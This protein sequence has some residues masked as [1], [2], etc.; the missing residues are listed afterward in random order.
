MSDQIDIDEEINSNSSNIS[1]NS[2]ENVVHKPWNILAEH[3]GMKIDEKFVLKLTKGTE[4]VSKEVKMSCKVLHFS[5]E[6]NFEEL[7]ILLDGLIH[8]EYPNMFVVV[9]EGK[10]FEFLAENLEKCDKIKELILKLSQARPLLLQ[11]TSEDENAAK[12]YYKEETLDY[13]I[14]IDETTESFDE[15]KDFPTLLCSFLA[16]KID[17]VDQI[18]AAWRPIIKSSLSLKFLKLFENLFYKLILEVAKSGEKTDLLTILEAPV[19]YEGRVL[20]VE[21]HTYQK[22]FMRNYLTISQWNTS[23]IQ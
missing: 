2:N 22:Y 6:W 21:A 3:P 11:M 20:S 17:N 12:F 18:T 14:N 23:K 4:N 1:R 5:S 15:I 13:F 19:E 7:L 9:I 10:I 16:G 8:K